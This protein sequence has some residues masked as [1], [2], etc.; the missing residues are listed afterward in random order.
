MYVHG[1]K[2]M[3][4]NTNTNTNANA[5]TDTDTDDQKQKQKRPLD[6]DIRRCGTRG[7]THLT[8]ARVDA[9]IARIHDPINPVDECTAAAVK[10]VRACQERADAYDYREY[11]EQI[12]K[13]DRLAKAVDHEIRLRQ[14]KN[15]VPSSQRIAT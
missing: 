2:K 10:H 6:G 15:V 11:F 13:I 4:A 1:K 9:F 14:G 5:D 3:N 12:P 7:G 8:D